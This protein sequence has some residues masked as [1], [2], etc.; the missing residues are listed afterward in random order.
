M[1]VTKQ[2]LR[3]TSTSSYS[4]V[5]KK[6]AVIV[7]RGYAPFYTSYLENF[8]I[9]NLHKGRHTPLQHHGEPLTSSKYTYKLPIRESPT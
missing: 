2:I 7:N 3:I 4:I 6:K 5:K 9:K 1:H 8:V